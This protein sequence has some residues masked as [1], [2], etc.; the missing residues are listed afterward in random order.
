MTK[1]EEKKLTKQLR[2]PR[3]KAALP[4]FLNGTP[5]LTRDISASGVFIVQ[6]QRQELGSKIEF[7]VDLDTPGGKL[8]LN[9]QGEVVRIE[10][11]D[12]RFGIGVKI[13]KQVIKGYS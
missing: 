9:C 8:K 10:E 5:A 3:V 12:G 6:N 13:L 11:M 2:R 7:W 4:T 1:S